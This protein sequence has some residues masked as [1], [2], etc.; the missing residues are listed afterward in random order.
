M[1]SPCPSHIDIASKKV[2]HNNNDND[3]NAM[4]SCSSLPTTSSRALGL[5]FSRPELTEQL[6]E[7]LWVWR[8]Q[9]QHEGQDRGKKV[10]KRLVQARAKGVFQRKGIPE[11]KVY[12]LLVKI[13][14]RKALFSNDQPRKS[15]NRKE[16]LINAARTVRYWVVSKLCTLSSP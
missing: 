5:R 7:E 4:R 1:L 6:E 10:P 12:V 16:T 13:M 3:D 15:G 2:L 9:Q 11:F 14:Q 8:Q